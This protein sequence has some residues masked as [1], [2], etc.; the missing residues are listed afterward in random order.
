MIN[1]YSV[2]D[3]LRVILG[4]FVIH[5]AALIALVALARPPDY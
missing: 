5:V 4:N 2:V 1:N 3:G